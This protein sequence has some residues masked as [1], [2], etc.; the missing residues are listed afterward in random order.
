MR[1]KEGGIGGVRDLGK[2]N[3]EGEGEGVKMWV[4]IRGREV[5]VTKELMI[6]N[7]GNSNTYM[8]SVLT[9]LSFAFCVVLERATLFG[10]SGRGRIGD[11]FIQNHAS[12]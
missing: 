10:G 3:G 7:K 4:C 1:W 6:N 5:I 9:S 2:G 12:A 8:H 11:T